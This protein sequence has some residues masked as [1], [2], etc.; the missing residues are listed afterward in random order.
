MWSAYRCSIPPVGYVHVGSLLGTEVL[1][2][3]HVWIGRRWSGTAWGVLNRSFWDHNLPQGSQHEKKLLWIA[4]MP[5]T[6][7]IPAR[8]VLSLD[9]GGVKGMAILLILKRLFRTIQ[10]NEGLPYTPRPCTYFDLIGGTS[11]GGY[12]RVVPHLSYTRRER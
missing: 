1:T 2:V 9:G 6:R 12:V 4:I 5:D 7:T 8:R 3:L 10:H 11:T